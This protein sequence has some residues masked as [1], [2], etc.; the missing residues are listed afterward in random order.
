MDFDPRSIDESRDRDDRGRELSQGS[1]GGL[2]NP[3]E[4][5]PLDV[6]DVFTRDLQ[7]PRGTERERVW[8]R[9]S[10][11]R[12]RGSEVRTLATVGAFRVVPAGDL[13]DGQDRPLDP[14]RG[15]LR[16]LRDQGLVETIPAIGED[17]ALVVLTERGRDVLERNRWSTVHR[18][19]LRYEALHQ[20]LMEGREVGDERSRPREREV[21]QEFYAGVRS[22]RVQGFAVHRPREL[23]HDAQVYRAYLKEAERLREQGVSIRRVVLDNELKR[24]YQQ[25]LQERNRGRSDSDGRPDRTPEEIQ[26]W[27]LEH[28]LPEQDGHV[29]FPDARIECEDRDGRLRT[30]DL[31]VETLHYRGGH[32]TA[33]ASSGFT[34][35]SAGTTRV[36]GSRGGAGGGAGRGRRYGLTITAS[37]GKSGGRSPDPRLAEELLR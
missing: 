2:S 17:R 27:A 6:R 16:N 22:G 12:L 25:F 34:R 23:T 32:A 30:E 4:R 28:N 37:T 14:N 24:E 5:E 31:E 10:D 15:D 1:R 21:R 35:Y 29:Q 11:V 3:R 19:A 7:L 33:K 13:R 20:A 18:E 9:D 8:A 26:R 36:V